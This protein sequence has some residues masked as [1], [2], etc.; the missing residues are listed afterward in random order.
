M[1]TTPQIFEKRLAFLEGQTTGLLIALR[2]ALNAS[3]NS[4]HVRDAIRAAIESE[5][6]AHTELNSSEDFVHGLKSIHLFTET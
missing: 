1:T 4:N 5:M 2:N 6:A 3:E